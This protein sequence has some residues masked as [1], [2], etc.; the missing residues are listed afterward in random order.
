MQYLRNNELHFMTKNEV[1][2][3]CV[4]QLNIFSHVTWYLTS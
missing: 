4:Q 3:T 1:T 2:T